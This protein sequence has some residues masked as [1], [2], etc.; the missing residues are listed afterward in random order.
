MPHLPMKKKVIIISIAIGLV[1]LV[2]LNFVFSR[3]VREQYGFNQVCELIQS[4]HPWQREGTDYRVEY[5][6]NRR[7]TEVADNGK[8]YESEYY[9]RA[10]IIR[11]GIEVHYYRVLWSGYFENTKTE[12]VIYEEPTEEPTE[13]INQEEI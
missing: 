2:G 3:W 10:T 5:L 7:P 13:E 12:E 1:I 9:Y 11:N 8:P 6:F 4:E